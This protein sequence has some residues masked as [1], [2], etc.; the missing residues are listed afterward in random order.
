MLPTLLDFDF[1]GRESLEREFGALHL[2]KMNCNEWAS[3]MQ[4]HTQ[5]AAK[6]IRPHQHVLTWQHLQDALRRLQK[7]KGKRLTSRSGGFWRNICAE[8]ISLWLSMMQVLGDSRRCGWMY[9]IVNL[10]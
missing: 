5:R 2:V 1:I 9:Y 7:W 6:T 8:V 10:C 4:Y 3:E